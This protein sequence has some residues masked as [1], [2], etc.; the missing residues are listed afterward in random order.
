MKFLVLLV[1]ASVA[2]ASPVMMLGPTANLQTSNATGTLAEV[3]KAEIVRQLLLLVDTHGKVPSSWPSTFDFVNQSSGTIHVRQQVFGFMSDVQ[4]ANFAHATIQ[5][6]LGVSIESGGALCGVGSGA[7][8]AASTLKRVNPFLSAGGHFQLVA[9]ES[10]FSRTFGGCKSQAQKVTADEIAG[11][12]ATW[13]AGQAKHHP[14]PPIFFLYDALPHMTVGKW[15]RNVPQYDL[16]LGTLL[17]LLKSS[18]TEHKVKLTGYFLD[19]P[20][21]YSRDFPNATSPM[22][23][24]SGFKKIAAAVQLVKGMGLQI[25]KTFNSQQGGVKS[26]ELF[27]K[28]TLADWAGTEAAGASFDFMMVETWY[29]HP[30]QAAPETTAYTTTNTAKAVFG[31]AANALSSPE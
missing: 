23:A 15:P 28:N 20:Y 12:A 26:D 10:I 17:S 16:D 13:A 24:G 14:E 11:Y 27:Y 30:L 4:Q 22:P 29:Y 2:I 21:E 6:G 31:K 19:C 1:G 18:M 25:G 9:L 3:D 7:K 8:N 5:L